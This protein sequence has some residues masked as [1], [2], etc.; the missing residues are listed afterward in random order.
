MATPR[1]IILEMSKFWD[2]IGVT[3]VV[4]KMR[5]ARLR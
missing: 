2:K 3:S 1:L 4:D 5:E